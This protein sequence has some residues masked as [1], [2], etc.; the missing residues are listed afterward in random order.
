M[1]PLKPNYAN[2]KSI[3]YYIKYGGLRKHVRLKPNRTS[4]QCEVCNKTF[5]NKMLMDF[6]K[7]TH[8]HQLPF[9]DFEDNLND[10]DNL[11]TGTNLKNKS[12]CR[13]KIDLQ[14]HL[15]T[16]E[17]IVNILYYYSKEI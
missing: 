1:N 17:Q 10:G 14:M 11:I 15:E 16:G 8:P 2:F 13:N 5:K 9:K 7:R 6:H 12:E 3:R 4:H